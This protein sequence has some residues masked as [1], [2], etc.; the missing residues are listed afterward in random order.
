MRIAVDAMGGDFGASPLVEGALWALKEK[1]FSL[2]LIGDEKI[3]APLIP[4]QVSK[5]VKIVHC[6]DFIAM[7]DSA[8]AA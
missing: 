2:V 1:D 4:A 5:E 3:L 7:D 6:D 8:T